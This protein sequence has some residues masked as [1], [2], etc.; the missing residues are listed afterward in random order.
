MKRIDWNLLALAAASGSP[1]QP[2]Q[3]QKALFFFGKMMP[4]AVRGD[5]YS[6][7]PYHYG[8]FDKDV[9]W[10]AGLL[11]AKGLA[12]VQTGPFKTYGATPEGLKRADEL[13]KSN[14]RGWAYL[15]ELVTWVR[16]LSF[17]EL[18]RAVYAA[19]PEY[20]QNSVFQE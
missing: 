18:V 15:K 14:P 17:D 13:G 1:L 6:F 12:Y 11:A 9:Y 2:V 5:F 3:L 20:K 4:D 10:D 7:V 8:P 16:S 19:Y